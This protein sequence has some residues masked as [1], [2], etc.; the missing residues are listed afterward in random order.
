MP[1]IQVNTANLSDI[2]RPNCRTCGSRMWLSR[3]SQ[4]VEGRECRTFEC[5]VCE[6]STANGAGAPGGRGA[7]TPI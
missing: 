7:S 2:D 3:V 5:P 4:P 6:V 1:T